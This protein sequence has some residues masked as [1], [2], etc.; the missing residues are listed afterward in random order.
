MKARRRDGGFTFLEAIIVLAIT[1][2]V[3]AGTYAVIVATVRG[4]ENLRARMKLQLEAIR[5]LQELTSLLKTSGP[6]DLNRNGIRDA[7]EPPLFVQDGNP[8]SGSLSA[9]NTDNPAVVYGSPD[10]YGYGGRSVEMAFMLPGPADPSDPRGRPVGSDGFTR[11]GSQG[12]PGRTD[13]YAVV[14]VPDPEARTAAQ[15]QDP[16]RNELQLREYDASSPRTLLRSRTMA[17]GVERIVFQS[18]GP[19]TQ[20][21]TGAYPT[22]PEFANDPELGQP[23]GLHQIRVT[24][25]MRSVDMQG[26]LLRMR[27]SSTVNLRSID[28]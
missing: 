7:D 12:V 21:L 6:A 28:R 17:R 27:Q 1:A 14:L 26:R 25:W 9:L 15:R 22:S 10:P 4:D 24:L 20:L 2:V 3:V 5:T 11:W 18:S 13:V 19:A 16:A 8:W 23:L